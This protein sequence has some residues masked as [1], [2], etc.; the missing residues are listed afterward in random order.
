MIKSTIFFFLAITSGV[1]LGG[2][3]SWVPYNENTCDGI[4]TGQ[5]G[6]YI[7]DTCIPLTANTSSYYGFNSTTN[8]ISFREFTKSNSCVGD[9]I[10]GSTL[11]GNCNGYK[12]GGPTSPL[13]YIRVLATQE[14]I[15]PPCNSL[16]IVRRYYPSS[17]TNCGSNNYLWSRYQTN[18]TSILVDSNTRETFFCN[19]QNQPISRLCKIST[20]VCTDTQLLNSCTTA[21]A[22]FLGI[23]DIKCVLT[24]E[25][26]PTQ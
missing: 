18:G 25:T 1:V 9:S 3:V 7:L 10:S 8:R 23:T 14:P 19:S 16:S 17:E 6:S 11:N 15:Q 5:G 4:I 2:Y 12:P 20:G 24:K 21:P 13:T 22:P 26:L